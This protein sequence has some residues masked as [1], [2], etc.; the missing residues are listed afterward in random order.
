MN[1]PLLVRTDFLAT[2]GPV[3]SAAPFQTSFAT[4][5]HSS[6]RSHRRGTCAV[7][8]CAE[9]WTTAAGQP[10]SLVAAGGIHDAAVSQNR[11][12]NRWSRSGDDRSCQFASP[13][14]SQRTHHADGGNASGRSSVCRSDFRQRTGNHGRCRSNAVRTRRRYDRHQH[15]LPRQSHRRSGFRSRDD[16]QHRRYA[17]AGA[18]RCR[19]RLDSDQCQDATWL[20]QQQPFCSV[21]CASV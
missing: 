20:G 12:T 19:S 11:A 14:Q 2:K 17:E 3:S 7:S 4:H 10:I 6:D 21:L 15:G 18:D 16:V 5:L 9:V 13:S 1:V 8:R